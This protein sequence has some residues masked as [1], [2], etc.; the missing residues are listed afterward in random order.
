MIELMLI[1]LMSYM[2]SVVLI[3]SGAGPI[4][5]NRCCITSGK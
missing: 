5:R 1:M 4:L 2:L 3:L